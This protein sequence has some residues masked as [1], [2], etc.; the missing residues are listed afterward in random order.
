M[1]IYLNKEIKKKSEKRRKKHFM[2]IKVKS[3]RQMQ[4]LSLS[5]LRKYM[6]VHYSFTKIRRKK[7]QI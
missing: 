5:A 3:L 1:K 7:I 6:L 4:I 2:Q